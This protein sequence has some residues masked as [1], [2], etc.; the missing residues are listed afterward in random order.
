ME[1]GQLRPINK[2]GSPPAR[3]KFD[4]IVIDQSAKS[5]RLFEVKQERRAVSQTERCMRRLGRL[6]SVNL[7]ASPAP[8]PA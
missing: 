3:S 7:E 6:V 5:S 1:H 4:P 2:A 8:Y